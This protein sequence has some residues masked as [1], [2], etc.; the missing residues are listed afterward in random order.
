MV[1]VVVV[2]GEKETGLGL[3][4]RLERRLTRPER[5]RKRHPQE[6]SSP[7]V[8]SVTGSGSERLLVVH[9]SS[10]SRPSSPSSPFGL[11]SPLFHRCGYHEG[12]SQSAARSGGRLKVA[13]TAVNLK[14]CQSQVRQD[15]GFLFAYLTHLTTCTAQHT[16]SSRISTLVSPAHSPSPNIISTHPVHPAPSITVL[17]MGYNFH[18]PRSRLSVR[19]RLPWP[20]AHD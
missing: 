16:C 14:S 7:C 5:G 9:P 20:T 10:P 3:T 1:V 13:A 8:E 4:W 2:S 12:H 15:S 17:L 6:A 11:R 18:R 19:V